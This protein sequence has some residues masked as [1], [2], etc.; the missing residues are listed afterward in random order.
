MELGE[1]LNRDAIW[2]TMFKGINVKDMDTEL[3]SKLKEL[4]NSTDGEVITNFVLKE[5]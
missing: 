4:L 3:I 2:M 5:H 1:E